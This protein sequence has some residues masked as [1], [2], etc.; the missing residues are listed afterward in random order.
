MF[1][2]LKYLKPYSAQTAAAMFFMVLNNVTTL[3]LP[4]MLTNITN[5][6]KEGDIGYIMQTGM[7]ML[8]VSFAGIITSIIGSYF[9]ARAAMGF[10]A[11]L[12]REIFTKVESLS[13]GD[14][15]E[16][17]IPSLITRSTND[18]KHIQDMIV[19]GIRMIIA[20][21]VLLIGGAILA[22]FKNPQLSTVILAAIP[23]IALIVFLVAR[24]VIPMFDE[25]EKRTDRL[26]QVIREKISGIRVIRAFSRTE[27]EDEKFDEASSRLTALALKI[28]RIV[29]LLIPI[30]VSI[31]FVMAI[32]LVWLSTMQ[33]NRLDAVTQAETIATA[34]G[35]LQAF[36]LYLVV[37]L[38]AL[39]MA[40]TMFIMVPYGTISANRILEVLSIEPTVKESENPI[41]PDENIKGTL[42]FKDVYFGYPGAENPVLS[43]LSFKIE[44]GETVA[45]IGST[46]SGKSTLINLIP[47]F[48]DVTSGEILIDGV[49]VKDIPLDTL[50][51]K[52]GFVPQK[53]VLFSGTVADNLKFGKHD[54]TPEEI[55]KALEISQSTE[56]VNALPNK[57][58]EMIS[59][60]GNTLSGGQK[61]RLAIARALIK[62]AEFF[63]F[64]DSFS[65]VDLKTD[66]AL[67]QSLRENLSQ[68]TVIL[69]AQRIGTIQ[70]CDKIIVLEDGKIVGIGKHK[71]LLESCSVYREIADSQYSVI[72]SGGEQVE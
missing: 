33:I 34:V 62:N 29:A 71:E 52:I 41:V 72:E 22:V 30:G 2:V 63:I 51:G 53:A 1:K 37:I 55:E 17:G 32:S 27:Y 11:T 4:L 12:R 69:V 38:V 54:A 36:I 13:P 48:F 19:N 68:A 25:M 57:A 42:E 26:N 40:A 35:D 14:I 59:Q 9:T 10:G 58:Y 45:I 66:A 16:V 8:A 47:R 6:V 20:T 56:F 61:Q 18:V 5:G 28:N 15:N 31:L 65:A 3:V 7:Q 50:N 70:H 24:K 43:G 49:N 67:R 44:K 39:V 21:P 46:G 64:D 23:V 60:G